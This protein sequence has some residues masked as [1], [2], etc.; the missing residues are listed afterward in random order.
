MRS[1]AVVEADVGVDAAPRFGQALIDPEI[2]VL[3]FD[4]PPEALDINVVQATVPIRLMHTAP[5]CSVPLH[6]RVKHG[7]YLLCVCVKRIGKEYTLTSCPI[8]QDLSLIHI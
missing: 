4:R 2:D 8:F 6:S 3:V 5:T 7:I 1:L